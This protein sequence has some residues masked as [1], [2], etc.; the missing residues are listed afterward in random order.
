MWVQSSRFS[1][2]SSGSPFSRSTSTQILAQEY[3]LDLGYAL[4]MN[5]PKVSP[6]LF[7]TSSP[8]QWKGIWGS[9]THTGTMKG[10][11]FSGS[12]SDI[13]LFKYN[14]LGP[15]KYGPFLKMRSLSDLSSK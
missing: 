4:S 5:F 7:K 11:S 9:L 3:T 8:Q 15:K 13:H 10:M 1:L 12:K 6:I 14:P 2:I